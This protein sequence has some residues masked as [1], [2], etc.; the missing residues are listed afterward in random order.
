VFP[1]RYELYSYMLFRRN[2]KV[3]Q[4]LFNTVQD[5]SFLSLIYFTLS[6][7]I[8]SDSIFIYTLILTAGVDRM[9]NG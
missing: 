1:A 8:I 3:T 4:D 7:V 9:H 6:S 5:M 2:F